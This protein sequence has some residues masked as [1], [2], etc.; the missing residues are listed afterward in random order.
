M[1]HVEYLTKVAMAKKH[2]KE[3]GETGKRI[4]FGLMYGGLLGIFLVPIPLY[5]HVFALVALVAAIIFFLKQE[6]N[7][8]EFSKKFP[9]EERII[10]ECEKLLK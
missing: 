5:Q 9:E 8:N 2:R 10:A 1:E 4:Y 7:K 6:K 3:Y